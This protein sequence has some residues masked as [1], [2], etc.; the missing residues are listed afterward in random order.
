MVEGGVWEVPPF[1]PCV[2]G[3]RGGPLRLYDVSL[4]VSV[5]GDEDVWGPS[6]HTPVWCGGGGG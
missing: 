3:G 4:V 6:A 2:Q 1:C 5:T